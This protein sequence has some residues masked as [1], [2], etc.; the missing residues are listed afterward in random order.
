MMGVG[1]SSRSSVG[2]SGQRKLSN[3][4]QLIR[5]TQNDISRSRVCR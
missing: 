3:D 1:R 2:N 4:E 5:E